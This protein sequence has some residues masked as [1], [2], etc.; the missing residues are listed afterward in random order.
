M[1]QFNYPDQLTFSM[2]RR[3]NDS[4]NYTI[5]LQ[6]LVDDNNCEAF[7]SGL[8]GSATASIYKIPQTHIISDSLSV[9]DS[10]VNLV[11]DKDVGVGTW[12][13]G[14]GDPGMVFSSPHDSGTLVSTVFGPKD[15]LYY[16][17]FWTE[18]NWEYVSTDSVDIVFFKQPETSQAGVDSTVYFADT[19]RLFAADPTAG[20]GVWTVESGEALIDSVNDPRSKV[21]LG[22]D[23]LDLATEYAFKW[24]ITNGICQVVEDEVAISRRDMRRYDGFSPDGNLKNDYYVIRGLDYA[25]SWEIRFYSRH[26]NLLRTVTSSQGVPEDMLWDGKLEDGSD[27]EEGTYF[28]ILRVKKNN[29]NYE[30]KGTLEL[31]RIR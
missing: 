15:S 18:V 28:Y 31:A 3:T 8:T 27:A 22:G 6:S 2:P 29:R 30:Y 12:S 21:D 24:T 9:C 11:A 16:K 19:I 1:K 17:V 13:V 10:V 7:T 4:A 20:V 26:G 5:T 14:Q 23:D 25:D